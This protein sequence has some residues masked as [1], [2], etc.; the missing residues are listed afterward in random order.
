MKG[1]IICYLGNI[2]KWTILKKYYLII[3]K[4]VERSPFIPDSDAKIEFVNVFDATS[5]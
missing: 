3:T 1:N 2:T 4:L 5:S